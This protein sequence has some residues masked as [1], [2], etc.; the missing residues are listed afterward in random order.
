MSKQAFRTLGIAPTE[1]GRAIRAAFLRLAKIYHPDRFVDMPDDV[2]EEAERRMK[3]ATIAY[4]SLRAS[5]KDAPAKPDDEID[6]LEVQ[7][8]AMKFREVAAR[9]REHERLDREK[10]LRWERVEE[11]ARKRAKLEADLAHRVAEE[12][13]DP[14]ADGN[15]SSAKKPQEPRPVKAPKP[16]SRETLAER[17]DAA[18]RGENAPLEK[19][20]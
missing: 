17:L 15:G 9:Q 19:R 3:E 18:R 14:P 2:R 12:V 11:I 7:K 10:W 6:E 8:R 13:E 5:K 16:T 20:N 4:E 1:D